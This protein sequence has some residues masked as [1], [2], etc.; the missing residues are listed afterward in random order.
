MKLLKLAALAVLF[1][2]SSYAQGTVEKSLFNVQTG[3]TP[4]A[5]N[6]EAKLGDRFALRSELSFA[7]RAYWTLYDSGYAFTPVINLEPRWY[8]NIAKRER[9]DKRTDNNSANFIGLASRYSSNWVVLGGL[10]D[11]FTIPNSVSFVPKWGIRRGIGQSN[12]NY[13]FS[14]GLG[15][16]FYPDQE[17][18]KYSSKRGGFTVHLDFRIG[19]TFK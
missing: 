9:K 2:V 19:Y 11:Y 16:F 3:L 1:S 5:I 10:P 12:F 13:E 14:T 8:Y 15:Y 7:L 17:S 6:H 4:L 18:Q